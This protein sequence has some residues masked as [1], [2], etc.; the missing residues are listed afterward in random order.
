MAQLDK[1]PA[2]ITQLY[3]VLSSFKSPTIGHF[4]NSS[5]KMVDVTQPDKALC[6]YQLKR[7][8]NSQAVIMCC[9]SRDN[10]VWKV[11]EIGRL[12]QG[13]TGNY[14]PIEYS[15]AQCSLFW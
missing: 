14:D 5:Y 13:S 1:L 7:A 10:Q 12:S 2:E 3:F 6:S 9:V 4:P 8:A 15:I 11:I